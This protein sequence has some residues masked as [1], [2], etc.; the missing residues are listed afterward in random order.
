VCAEVQGG[1]VEMDV[2]TG[3]DFRAGL[4]EY[5][6][7]VIAALN[8][9]PAG[10]GDYVARFLNV[11]GG[12]KGLIPV[13]SLLGFTESVNVCYCHEKSGEIILMPELPVAWDRRRLDEV[14]GY[15]LRGQVQKEEYEK[16]PDDFRFLFN[17]PDGAD[18]CQL[19]ALGELVAKAPGRD[20]Q[21]RFGYG[22][23]LM[24]MLEPAD[25]ELLR[26][27]LPEWEH[28]W[29]GDQIPET[30]EHSRLHT[31]RLLGFAYQ[32]F[33]A[34]PELLKNVG[35]SHGLYL[36]ICALWLHDIGH[37]ALE[38]QVD[39]KHLPL[40]L[41]PSLVREWHH[42]TSAW[43][44]RNSSY[45]D[46]TKDKEAVALITE[47]HRGEMVLNTGDDFDDPY[48]YGIF[49]RKC[50]TLAK[51]LDKMVHNG[52]LP[53]G[54]NPAHVLA[55]AAILRFLDGCDVQADRV[56]DEKYRD[57]R[58]LRT[59][60]EV[61]FLEARLAKIEL[62]GAPRDSYKEDKTKRY[63]AFGNLHEKTEAEDLA[64]LQV[65]SLC[66]QIVFKNKQYEHFKEHQSI[67]L[68]FLYVNKD[69]KL[70]VGLVPARTDCEAVK[71]LKKRA[72]GIA[73]EY[74]LVKR[75]LQPVEIDFDGTWVVH[76][77]KEVRAKEWNPSKEEGDSI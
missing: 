1:G 52:G 10:N 63:K 58:E 68:A 26:R 71:L 40:A 31:L 69:R 51:R 67:E 49:M 33:S 57:A 77:N 65:V 42:Y 56:G 6:K 36:L 61:E 72:D 34:Y 30:V 2:N 16:L 66:D 64:K 47:Y 38:Y 24:R 53:N 76:K 18:H 41:M 32:L 50:P 3:A 59:K 46:D 37:S 35:G 20:L 25:A 17:V 55:I 29:L 73:N 8:D 48:G 43:M 5:V 70:R 45:L 60:R 75:I 62:S 15:V 44:I 12:Y 39:K 9:K 19:S 23:Y 74:C 28:L 11:T 22:R 54:I 13:L 4:A 7:T 27:K 21:T 14:R